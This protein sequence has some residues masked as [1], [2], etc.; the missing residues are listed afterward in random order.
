MYQSL[1]MGREDILRLKD[2]YLDSLTAGNTSS[3]RPAATSTVFTSAAQSALSIE[4]NMNVKDVD[5]NLSKCCNPQ[6]CD[7]IFGF[8]S[9]SKGI[10]IHRCDCAN[11]D[12]MRQRYPYR[13]V[14]ARWVEKKG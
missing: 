2:M 8:I 14:P 5:Y 9:I 1:A 4:V 7:P 11:A 3:E 6:P 10:R 13:I 12:N